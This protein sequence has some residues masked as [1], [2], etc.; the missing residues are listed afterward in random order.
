MPIKMPKRM[1]ILR[2]TESFFDFQTQCPHR[3][4]QG[5]NDVG[6]WAC[7]HPHHPGY[8]EPNCDEKICP[9]LKEKS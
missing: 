6:W 4:A 2:V 3:K 1:A 7:A 5:S 8:K 9:R